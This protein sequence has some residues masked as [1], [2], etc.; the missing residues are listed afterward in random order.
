MADAFD[1]I[2][3][4]AMAY[5]KDRG[6]TSAEVLDEWMRKLE[7]AMR[8]QLVPE[9]KIEEKLQQALGAVFRQQVDNGKVLARHPGVARYTLDRVRPELRAELTKRIAANAALIK[10]NRKQEIDATLRRFAGWASSVPTGGT[11]LGT[12]DAKEGIRK[13]FA[14]LP[15]KERRVLIDQG[16]KL[17]SAVSSIVATGGGAI[18]ATWFSHYHQKNYDF[19]EQHKKR[20]IDSKKKPYLIRNSWAMERGYLSRTGVTYTD[21]IEQPG[22]FVFCRCAYVYKFNLRDLPDDMLTVK[23]REAL[24]DARKMMAA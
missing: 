4:E 24:A 17:V 5:F 2:L 22:E 6:F 14:S 12:K 21:E 15:F 10:L 13:G 8:A 23:G 11:P 16:A 20:E 9:W 18:A 3:R 19:R 1:T 7:E